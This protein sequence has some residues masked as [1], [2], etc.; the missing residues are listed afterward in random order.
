MQDLAAYTQAL[1]KEITLVEEKFNAAVEEK[2][3][4]N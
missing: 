4:S 3:K 2:E 1:E